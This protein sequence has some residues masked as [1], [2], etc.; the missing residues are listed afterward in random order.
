LL[1]EFGGNKMKMKTMKLAAFIAALFLVTGCTSGPKASQQD[2]LDLAIR[3]ASDYL[4][5]NIPKGSK[6]V[7]LNVQSAS[8]ALSDYII[9]ELI[10]NAVNDKIFE[11]VD[12]QQLD[13][14]RSEQNFQWSGEVDDK[15]A[16]EVGKFFGA[17]T[18]VSGRV[19]QVAERY[20]FTIRALDVQSARVQGQ[21]NFNINAGKT[22]TAL[23]N[24][25]GGS[26]GSTS[27]ASGGPAGT[28]TQTGTTTA[29][30]TGGQQAQPA[31]P[32]AQP[33]RP[34]AIKNGTYYFFPRLLAIRGGRDIKA[35][36]DKIVVRSGYFNVY[37]VGAAV[38]GETTADPEGSNYWGYMRGEW[39]TLQDLDRPRIA[40]TATEGTKGELPRVIGFQNVTGNRF[41]L[42]FAYQNDTPAIFEEI[43]LSKAEYQP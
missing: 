10:A 6:I 4:N 3:D 30:G 26:S 16:L 1:I 28:R 8:T 18:I 25:K 32:T 23:M 21:N 19:S 14:I 33:A 43:D 29:S 35:Y 2:E 5:E 22:I 17:Q 37:V 36:L 39:F 7:I 13:L 24:S 11:V 31:Q 27:T 42:T 9:D 41:K 12:R 20:R 40:F 34:A 15:L 38:G